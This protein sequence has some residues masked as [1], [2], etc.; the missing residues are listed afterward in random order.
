MVG[1]RAK[2]FVGLSGGVDSSTAA[3][4]LLEEGY[5][6][7]GVFMIT[8]DKSEITQADAEAVAK[9]LG[10]KLYVLDLRRD[11]E[12]VLD[13]FCSEYKRGRTPNP[14]V[15]CNRHIKF[16]KLW[17]FAVANGA[18]LLATGHYARILRANDD[19]GLYEAADIAKDQSYALA[20]I[21]RSV[22]SHVI[23]PLGGQS[24]DQTRKMAA[25]LGIDTEKKEESQEICFI[26]DDYVTALEQRYPELVK[27]GNIVDSNGKILG[28]HRGVHRFTIGQRRGLRVAMGKPY[29]VVKIDAESNTITL[30]P[31]EEVMCSKLTASG[32]NWLVKEANSVFRARVKVRYNDRGAGAT[33]ISEGAS[34]IVEFDELNLA[35]TPGQLAAFY[36]QESRAGTEVQNGFASRVIGGGWIDN[37]IY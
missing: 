22:L 24:K 25:K 16:G 37:A 17:T 36:E 18:D 13:Y 3:A 23:F 9:N 33:V 2:V 1:K 7:A 21:D 5:D 14:C 35:I 26:A 27:R 8:S 6:C 34:A 31:K 19:V 12:Q 15:F 20:M 32:L 30:G 4:L 10:I 28:G 29:Y 11:F